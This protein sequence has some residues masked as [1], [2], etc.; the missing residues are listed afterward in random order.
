MAVVDYRLS[1]KGVCIYVNRERE[2]FILI[3]IY[4]G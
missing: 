1:L 4:R 2:I 3:F